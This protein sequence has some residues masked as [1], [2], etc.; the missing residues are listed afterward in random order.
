MLMIAIAS[1]IIVVL[2]VIAAKI[3][4]L[5]LLL[6]PLFGIVSWMG[7]V[8]PVRRF[9]DLGMSGWHIVWYVLLPSVV[10]AFG[11]GT[12]GEWDYFSIASVA[13]SFVLFMFLA[14]TPGDEG[15]NGYEAEAYR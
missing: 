10:G 13:I 2:P 8:I 1:V 5:L 4:W 6:V 3:P 14:V 11:S 15:A 9:H 7:I 12:P